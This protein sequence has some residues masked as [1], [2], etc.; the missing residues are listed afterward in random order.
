MGVNKHILH[1][2]VGV[3]AVVQIASDIAYRLGIHY[4]DVFPTSIL[5]SS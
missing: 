3:A 2:H 4:V 1:K 5:P